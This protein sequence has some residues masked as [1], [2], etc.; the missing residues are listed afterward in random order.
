VNISTD[1]YQKECESS[2]NYLKLLIELS[3]SRSVIEHQIPLMVRTIRSLD[4]GR[5]IA[6]EDRHTLGT[7]DGALQE[8]HAGSV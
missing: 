7:G 1:K 5:E 8:G 3:Y 4:R 2:C 6:S